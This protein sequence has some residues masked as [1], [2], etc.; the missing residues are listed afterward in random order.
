MRRF[1]GALALIFGAL[2]VAIVVGQN[3]APNP[4]PWAYGYVTPGPAPLPPPCPADAK[5]YTCSRP[6][7]PWVDDGILVK[8]PGSTRTF[9]IG[10]IQ[11]HYDPADWYPEDHPAR[12]PDIVQHGRE[13]D[14]LRACAH[15]HYHNGQGKP[16]NGHVTGLPAGYIRQQ[17]ALFK[18][19]GRQSADPRKANHAEMTQIAR[20]LSDAEVQAAA[21]YYSAIAW[22]P[23]VTVIESDTAPKTRQSPAGLFIPLGEE[24]EPLGQR[25]IEVPEFPDRTER[26]RDPKAGF[27]AY[28]PS[29]TIEKGKTLVTTGG[30]R[31]IQCATCHGATLQGTGDV[32]AIA[33]RTVSYTVRQLYNYRQGTRQSQ[34]MKPIVAKLSADDVIAI[35]AYLG[36]L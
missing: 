19:G 8:L 12:V 25:F 22:R 13:S 10:Q 33:D 2:S 31:T 24:T 4:V 14:R 3:A 16:E 34:L 32:P 15:C 28:V 18:S 30:G 27:V 21:E 20:L 29:G 1:S 36:S 23:W 26:L 17:L 7:R 6:G 5:P 35:A 11:A 9:T